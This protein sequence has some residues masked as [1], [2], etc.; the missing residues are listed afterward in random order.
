MDPF[1]F[2][3]WRFHYFFRDP[4]RHPPS[5]RVIVAPADGVLLYVRRVEHNQLPSPLKQGVSIGL[6]EW[7]DKVEAPGAG[8]LIGIYM[9][10][11]SVHYNRAPVAGR[12]ARVVPRPARERN[13]SMT[14]PFMRLLWGMPPY[15]QGSRYVTENA[16]N[17]IVIDG[18]LP[19]IVVQI[20]DA[21]VREIDCFVAAG[22]SVALGQK[23]GMIR[24][25]SQCD[26][27]VPD[28]PALKLDCQPGQR[29]YAG[30]TILGGY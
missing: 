2:L 18:E 28:R 6:E 19:V 12:I 25:G 26:V 9:T 7:L 3:F 13:L 17:T 11:L 5:G 15:E 20:A 4:V 1:S 30:E 24:M 27:F 22:E 10:P 14:K 8:W 23:I 29:V 21:Y 16:R